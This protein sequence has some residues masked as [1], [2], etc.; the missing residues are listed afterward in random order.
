VPMRSFALLVVAAHGAKVQLHQQALSSKMADLADSAKVLLKQVAYKPGDV[1]DQQQLSTS[2]KNDVVAFTERAANDTKVVLEAIQHEHDTDVQELA[3]KFQTMVN[4]LAWRTTRG[5]E[6]AGERMVEIALKH[7]HFDCRVVQKGNCT[8][9]KYTNEQLRIHEENMSDYEVQTQQLETD[10]KARMCVQTNVNTWIT[11]VVIELQGKKTEF[12]WYETTFWSYRE[13]FY[14]L[15]EATRQWR[16]WPA[17][18]QGN[19]SETN[20]TKV[21]CNLDQDEL[22]AQSCKRAKEVLDLNAKFSLD[23]L[24]IAK[25]CEHPEE[26]ECEDKE[27]GTYLELCCNIQKKA[28]NRKHEWYGTKVVEC[29]LKRI[30]Q[31]Q[32]SNEPCDEDFADNETNAEIDECH[33]DNHTTFHLNINCSNIPDQPAPYC[34]DPHPCVTG[35]MVATDEKDFAFGY[36]HTDANS[37]GVDDLCRDLKGC[38]ECNQFNTADVPNHSTCEDLP[39]DCSLVICTLDMCPN[40]QSRSQIGDNC[41]ACA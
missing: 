15:V 29:L 9:E 36:T 39:E 25:Q 38:T 31:H 1:E 16:P 14:S 8:I 7:E 40:G 34:L 30:H 12:E 11:E 4:L 10:I 22:E 2:R 18:Q 21:Q 33:E 20:V 3:N 27:C 35:W 23:W 6:I 17:W 5:R 32:E 28:E 24:T 37:D 41:C 19:E 26:K 13:T